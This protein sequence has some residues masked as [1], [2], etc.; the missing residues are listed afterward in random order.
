MDIYNVKSIKININKSVRKK[1]VNPETSG[2]KN[3]KSVS[4]KINKIDII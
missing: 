4:N 2:Y 1:K 3:N